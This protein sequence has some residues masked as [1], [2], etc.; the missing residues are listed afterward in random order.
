MERGSRALV[1]GF[2]GEIEPR[3]LLSNVSDSSWFQMSRD[4]LA[5][6]SPFLAQIN[7]FTDSLP[8]PASG[9]ALET[10]EGLLRLRC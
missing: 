3:A 1:E 9:I 10:V 4:D 6:K 8:T 7:G 5:R 2:P